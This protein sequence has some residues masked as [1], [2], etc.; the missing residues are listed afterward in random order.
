MKAVVMPTSYVGPDDPLR[1]LVCLTSLRLC[2]VAVL[3]A[4]MCTAHACE[5]I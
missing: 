2:S 1:H 4:C 5:C 3:L